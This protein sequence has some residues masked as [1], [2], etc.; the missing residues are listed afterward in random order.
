MSGVGGRPDVDVLVAGAG[1]VGLAVAL[2]A[3]RA[4]FS[5]TVVEPRTDPVD[6][7]CGEGLMPG[8]LAVLL[9][10]DVD[11][12]GMP[13]RGIRYVDAVRHGSA[14]ALFA[15]G[16][17]RGVRRTELHRAMAVAAEKAGVERRT[18]SVCDIRQSSGSVRA[19][20]LTARWLVAADG[21][22]SP[23]RREL[24]LDRPSGLR[25]RYGLRRHFT[26]PPWTDLVEVHWSGRAEAYV[27]PVGRRTVGVA[28][29]TDQRGRS[30]DE[31][32]AGFGE[33]AERL[34]GA[35]PASEVRGAGPLGCASDRRVA[36]RVLLAGDAAG[37]VDAL[38]GEGIAV[39][40]AQARALVDCLARGRPEEYERAWR[41]STRRYRL[42]TRG[43]L[44][45]AQ[46][47]LLRSRLV[48]AAAAAPPVFR[49]AVN[50]LA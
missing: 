27:T 40:L 24:G 20:G 6:K 16:D 5:A 21:L 25:P 49:A 43:V 4:G 3:T 23:V 41:A 22:H 34:R 29:L 17:G 18:G 47:P 37:Y 1:P 39:G 26:I 8:A 15:A 45:A 11:P 10:L 48:P 33:L 19:A 31:W 13:F 30:F 12:A 44:Y 14:E 38:T 36:G 9:S 50:A 46:H 2:L 32:L 28:V 42:L 35:E 7:A